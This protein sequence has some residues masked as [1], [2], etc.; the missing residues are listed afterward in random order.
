MFGFKKTIVESVENLTEIVGLKSKT[1]RSVDRLVEERLYAQVADELRSGNTRPG[2]YAK[3]IADA[4]GVVSKAEA[5]YIK[6][7]VRSLIDEI[8]VEE[9]NK[10]IEE[11]YRREVREEQIRL[12]NIQLQQKREAEQRRIDEE[13]KKVQSKRVQDILV[14]IFI[15]FT[16]SITYMMLQN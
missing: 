13:A 3:A 8:I 5:L 2:I 16:I 11:E 4:E 15:L 6:Y 14:T 12:E 10:R 7:R 9:E 1:E